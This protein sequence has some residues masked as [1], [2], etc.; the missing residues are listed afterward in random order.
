MD[1]NKFKSSDNIVEFCN[2]LKK[3]RKF[4]CGSEWLDKFDN[5]MTIDDIGEDV[6]N[7]PSFPVQWAYWLLKFFG[8]NIDI[9]IRGYMFKKI[10]QHEKQEMNAF[11]LWRDSEWL[12]DDEDII[13]ESIWK[14][15]LPVVESELK[16]GLH[17]RVKKSL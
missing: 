4:N 8:K 7:D 10:L 15:K 2:S 1:N 3:H 17:Q 16:K 14:N 5:S 9:N 6:C 12:T 11:L 13:L